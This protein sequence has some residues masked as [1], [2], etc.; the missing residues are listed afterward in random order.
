[1]SSEG[2][3]EFAKNSR[4]NSH[5][6]NCI[7]CKQ[8]ESVI[9]PHT[10]KIILTDSTLYNVWTY[11]NLTTSDHHMEIESVVG[12]RIRNLT[13]VIMMLYLKHPE[14]LEIII[15]AGINNVG[16][17]QAVHEI[18][19][20]IYELK[21]AVMAHS[22]MHDHNPPSMVSVSTVMYA[23]KFCSLDVP[24]NKPDWA[25]PA[26]F[27]NKRRDIE[28]LNAAIAAQNKG[29]GVNYLNLHLEG[30]RI[31]KKSGKKL[32]RHNPVKPIWREADIR[33]RL[34]MSPDMKVRMVNLAKNLFIGGLTRLGDWQPAQ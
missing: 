2:I 21:E 13:R 19:D 30:I 33:R 32:H 4:N 34:H 28:C 1:M 20:E 18:L 22:T 10:R 14:R 7:L 17:G 5:L 3:R 15:I 24:V 9:R 12:A 8:P 16:E 23:P 26:G 27:V 31:D 29:N 25:P 6:F 11:A